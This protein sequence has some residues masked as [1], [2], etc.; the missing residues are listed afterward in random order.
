MGAFRR[1]VAA[2]GYTYV[3]WDDAFMEAIRNDW[4]RLR[5]RTANG[6]APPANHQSAEEM[7]TRASIEKMGI[8]KGLGPWDSLAEQFPAYKARVLKAPHIKGF[9]L[10]Q[11]AGMASKRAGVAA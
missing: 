11:L 7:E 10:D 5:G 8:D 1:K 2:N 9:S 4:A 6:A 3:N